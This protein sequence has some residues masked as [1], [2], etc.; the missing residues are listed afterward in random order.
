[1]MREAQKLMQDPA[2]QAQMKQMMAGA[3]F[4]QAMKKTKEEMKDPKKMAEMERKAQEAIAEGNKQ[5]EEVEKLR[6]AKAEKGD[7]D[8]DKK[9]AADEKKETKEEETTEDK[10]EE[11]EVPDIP[12][13]SLN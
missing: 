10:K 11:E 6:K 7:D 1:M 5:L 13:L 2:F 12:S 8:D 9:P 4:Q 3:G